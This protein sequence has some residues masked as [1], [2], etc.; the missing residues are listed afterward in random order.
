[1]A[2]YFYHNEPHECFERPAD[3]DASIWRYMDLAKFVSI[4]KEQAIFF[5]RADKL[6][7]PFEGSVTKPTRLM[8]E[9]YCRTH[10][11][12]DNVVDNFRGVVAA[13][14]RCTAVSC[15]HANDCESAAMW[16]LYLSSG[17]G[18]AIKSTFTRLVTSLP[19]WNKETDVDLIY[20]G[21]VKYI[22][23]DTTV[24]PQNNLYWPFVHKR[25]S[26]RHENEIRA[27]MTD[28]KG[29]WAGTPPGYVSFPNGGA[30]V[31][32]NLPTLVESVFVAPSA[33]RWFEEVVR[34]LVDK[35]GFSFPVHRSRLG[36]D[37]VY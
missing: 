28:S 24:M 14:V 30:S 19:Q 22:D 33:P 29:L 2:K 18:V 17:E 21:V 27:V 7:D 3:P 16:R 36:E 8:L 10:G 20:A 12:P 13:S 1:M 4:L 25:L 35:Y 32:V 9:E 34:S 6:G 15:W 37:P 23:Y 11:L 5:A 31:P 26:F